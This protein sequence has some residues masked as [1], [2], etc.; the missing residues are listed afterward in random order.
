MLDIAITM[1]SFYHMGQMSFRGRPHILHCL[2][3]MNSVEQYGE[4]AMAVAILHDTIEDTTISL[5][6]IREF[7]GDEVAEAVV[8]L[9][10]RDNES[11]ENYIKRLST[12]ELAVKVKL[13]DLHDNMRVER[14]NKITEGSI[15]RLTKYFNAKKYLENI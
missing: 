6:K 9:T 15:K 8:A 2:R 13:A 4:K 14:L 1:A 12:N 10:H 3:V 7:C 11:Y 5:E